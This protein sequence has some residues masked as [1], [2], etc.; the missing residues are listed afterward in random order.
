MNHRSVNQR[1]NQNPLRATHRTDGAIFSNAGLE[2]SSQKRQPFVE[3]FNM[4]HSCS[5]VAVA[6]IAFSVSADSME[7]AKSRNPFA[8]PTNSPSCVYLG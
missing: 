5:N 6:L 4:E 8:L 2:S 1:S 3:D 7:A